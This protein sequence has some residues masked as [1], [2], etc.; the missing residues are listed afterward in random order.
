MHK[1]KGKIRPTKGYSHV[2]HVGLNLIFVMLL[3]V[4]MRA[5][6]Y[7]LAMLLILISKW[8]IFAVKPRYWAAHIKINAVDIVVGLSFLGLIYSYAADNALN[9]LIFSVGYIGWLLFLKPLSSRVGILIQA[10][11]AF[12][13]GIAM[14]LKS[15]PNLSLAFLVSGVAVTSYI[16][17]LHFISNYKNY[18]AKFYARY[19]S[20]F[21]GALMWSMGHWLVYYKFVPVYLILVAIIM[22]PLITAVIISEKESSNKSKYLRQSAIFAL[23][24]LVVMFVFINWQSTKI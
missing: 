19:W 22:Y 16:S 24:L 11:V 1:L 8:R 4:L 5:E 3:V 10:L 23:A 2:A 17:A 7:S 13:L 15:F 14:L 18:Q 20:F 9:Q 12:N 6:F 21:C